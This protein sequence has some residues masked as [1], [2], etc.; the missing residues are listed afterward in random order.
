M[1]KKIFKKIL[2]ELQF[3]NTNYYARIT[4][5]LFKTSYQRKLYKKAHQLTPII[6]QPDNAKLTIAI[7]ANKL[8]FYESVA[9]LYSFCFWKQDVQVHYHEDGS[10]TQYEMDF[11]KQKFPGIV[12]FIR[13]EQNVKV[14]EYLLSKGLSHCAELRDHFIFSLRLFD[15]LIH[16]TTPYL[17]QVDSDVLFF[18]KPV[19][20][21]ELLE[22]GELN[23]CYNNDNKNAYT[24]DNDIMLKHLGKPVVNHF[25]AG[26]FLHNF[27]ETFFDFI[28][29]VLQ[30]EP[31]SVNSWHLEQTLFAMNVT[32]KGNFLSLPKTYDLAR[33]QIKLG[34]KVTSQHYCHNTGYNFHKDFLYNISPLF[35]ANQH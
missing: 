24:F 29:S 13:A 12:V 25:N 15:M 30:Q 23:G 28:E 21:L 32:R 9:T 33:Q 14:K 10:L 19:E 11:L 2:F 20:I 31:E 18:D 4:D 16:K 17:M 27:D 3:K 35:K 22:K 26:L 34:N 7:L 5:K 6:L 1:L 8:N